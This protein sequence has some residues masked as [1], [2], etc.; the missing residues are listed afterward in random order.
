M[1]KSY[2]TAKIT[3]PGNFIME[4]RGHFIKTWK[5]FKQNFEIVDH[6]KWKLVAVELYS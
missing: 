2:E 1:Q 4:G 3:N 6:L 5:M